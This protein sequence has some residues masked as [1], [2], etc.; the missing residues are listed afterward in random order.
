M[1][2]TCESGPTHAIGAEIGSRG[3]RAVICDRFGQT[4]DSLHAIRAPLTALGTVD[5]LS[6]LIEQLIDKAHGQDFCIGGIGIAFGGPVD[7]MRGITIGMPRSQGFERFPLAGVIEDRFQLP[8]TVENDGRAAAFGEYRYGAG[9]G[10]RSMIYMQLGIGIGGGVVL[11]GRLH[12]GAAMTAGEFGHIPVTADGPRCS[13]GK[14]G[15]LEAY[16]S[17]TVLVDRLRDSLSSAAPDELAYWR[18]LDAITARDIF[19]RMDEDRLA[20]E[21]T[22]EAIQ[23]IGLA[24]AG[25][26]SALNFDSVVFGGYATDLGNRFIASVRSRIRQYAFE[27]AGRRVTVSLG[28]L[29]NNAAVVGATALTFQ[30]SQIPD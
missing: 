27:E 22:D 6:D 8:T 12:H 1:E 21:I 3:L 5:A 15:H 11:D 4:S 25:M 23:M 16:I 7:P 17:E 24:V 14:P 26:V 2:S 19:R 20:A 29:G 13:C 18:S 10:S 9:R 28:Q 30:L